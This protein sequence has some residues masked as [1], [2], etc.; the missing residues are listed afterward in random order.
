MVYSENLRADRRK[1]LNSFGASHELK[2]KAALYNVGDVV[3]RF[4]FL[5]WI[6]LILSLIPDP[7]L[8]GVR[9]VLCFISLS[10]RLVLYALQEVSYREPLQ[11]DQR[12]LAACM[13][14]NWTAVV[15]HLECVYGA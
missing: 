6:T 10:I 14:S 4:E 8:A 11:Q 5:Y 15:A 9:L 3:A 12:R 1:H 2:H 7:V 13:P